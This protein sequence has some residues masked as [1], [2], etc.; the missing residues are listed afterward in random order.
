MTFLETLN[1]WPFT[2]AQGR[3]WAGRCGLQS[4]PLRSV[5]GTRLE[6]IVVNLIQHVAVLVRPNIR[7]RSRA[8]HAIQVFN[9][10]VP[11]RVGRQLED[12]FRSG[13]SH[14]EASCRVF[15]FM[16][17]PES[18]DGQP[19]FVQ[20][21]KAVGQERQS[22]RILKLGADGLRGGHIAFTAWVNWTAVLIDI[23]RAAHLQIALLKDQLTFIEIDAARQYSLGFSRHFHSEFL[24]VRFCGDY[25]IEEGEAVSSRQL[26]R[27]Y[28]P[29]RRQQA[30]AAQAIYAGGISV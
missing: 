13:A 23:C 17:K 5:S 14:A 2:P 29:L 1:L 9:R 15:G 21:D 8:K 7:Q 10:P 26:P 25:S 27:H 6:S 12:I 11:G 24:F 20:A 19:C 16:S 30:S 22:V 18:N 4:S 3:K 28:F